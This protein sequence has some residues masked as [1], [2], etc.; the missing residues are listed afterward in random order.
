V[1]QN[2]SLVSNAARNQLKHHIFVIHIADQGQG[3]GLDDPLATG[4]RWAPA[5]LPG[6]S[7]NRANRCPCGR[8]LRRPATSAATVLRLPD[9]SNLPLVGL[10]DCQ[11]LSSSPRL[12]QSRGLEIPGSLPS[13]WTM[14]RRVLEVRRFRESLQGEPSLQVIAG[15]MTSPNQPLRDMH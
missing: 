4:V 14:G 5:F 10:E 1:T 9:S 15:A 7:L 8:A 11:N 3:Q 6:R 12:G 2:E 13:P